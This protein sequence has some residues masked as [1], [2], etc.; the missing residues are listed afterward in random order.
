METLQGKIDASETV[1]YH[2]A[3]KAIHGRIVGERNLRKLNR[4]IMSLRVLAR[5]ESPDLPTTWLRLEDPPQP[6]DIVSLGLKIQ[7][8]RLLIEAAPNR[9]YSDGA[10]MLDGS[11]P[12]GHDLE[13]VEEYIHLEL[14]QR[15]FSF[16][17][18]FYY[19]GHFD[20]GIKFYEN[21]EGQRAESGRYN[22]GLQKI[23]DINEEE[24]NLANFY[25]GNCLQQLGG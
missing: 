20:M 19:D 22:P 10:F 1:P 23:S 24:T 3:L 16:Y 7:K 8:L 18:S 9:I 25:L 5:R 11:E 2:P 15:L 6:N 12:P 21:K 4:N 13:Y 17:F 14:E